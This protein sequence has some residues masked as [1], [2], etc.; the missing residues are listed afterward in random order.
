LED[1]DNMNI[2]DDSLYIDIYNNFFYNN[3]FLFLYIF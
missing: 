1:I 3:S 2:F